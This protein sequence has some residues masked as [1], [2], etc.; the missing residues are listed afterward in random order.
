MHIND[1]TTRYPRS[2]RGRLFRRRFR[3]PFP[4]FE[5]LM[6]MAQEMGFERR[7]K[8]AANVE[9]IPLELQILGVLRV[10][11]RG[12]CFDGIEELTNGSAEAHRVFFHKFCKTFCNRYFNE[13]VY[14]P[15]NEEE[16]RR[17]ASD[18]SRM[19]LPGAI[20]STDC[21]HV[22]WERCPASR[23]NLYTGK[24]GYRTISYQATVN[25][26]M[27][28]I[29]VTR[30]FHGSANDKTICK[31]CYLTEKMRSRELFQDDR[32]ELFTIDGNRIIQQGLYLICDGG[33]LKCKC[34]ITSFK[35][36][37]A[38]KIALW[39]EQME[40]ARKDVERAFG[41]LKGRFRNCQF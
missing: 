2:H 40:S 27:R 18:Y 24:E 3:V 35:Q 29:S 7:P 8:S 20:G 26:K 33:F 6:E 25:H 31:Y 1:A 17:W 5:Q 10:L 39:S 12:T 28:F 4:I 16:K 9:G 11:G 21:V 13:Y 41:I 14:P 23:S 19:G 36:Y 38:Q 32:Y 37:S 30:G 34:M 22:K 15:R